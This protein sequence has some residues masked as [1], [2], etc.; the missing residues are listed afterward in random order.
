[1]YLNNT[2]EKIVY[3]ASSSSRVKNIPLFR[4]ACSGL[5]STQHLTEIKSVIF[6][7]FTHAFLSNAISIQLSLVWR[8]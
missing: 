6:N 4:L 7:I 1:M 2:T 3:G 8:Y 5:I